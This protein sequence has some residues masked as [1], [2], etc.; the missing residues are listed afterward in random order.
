MEKHRLSCKQAHLALRNT[1][2]RDLIHHITDPNAKESI[3]SIHR[4]LA[5]GRE[6]NNSSSRVVEPERDSQQVVTD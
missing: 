4:I 6:G 2:P 3:Y 5:I 1:F